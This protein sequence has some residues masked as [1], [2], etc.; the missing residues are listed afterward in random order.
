MR[1]ERLP[2]LKTLCFR[3]ML[4]RRRS[5]SKAVVNVG[6][7]SKN[8]SWTGVTDYNGVFP[9]MPARVNLYLSH[10]A[11]WN[12]KKTASVTGSYMGSHIDY[13]KGGS[14]AAT[15]VLSDRTTTGTSI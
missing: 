1:T 12:N 7:A 2:R 15:L 14:D 13:F 6:L 8:S 11:V 10:D 9:A 3:E 5:G 4:H